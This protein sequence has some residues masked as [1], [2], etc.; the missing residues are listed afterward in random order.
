MDMYESLLSPAFVLNE[1]VARQLYE[2][3]PE[4]GLT[5]LIMDKKG[6]IWPSDSEE[7]AKF[8]INGV[9][10]KELR[11]KIDDGVEPV[12]T[13]IDDCSIIASQLATERSNCGYIIIILPQYSPESTLINITLIETLL[14]QFNLIANL[15]E[16]NNLLYEA[17]IQKYRD[18]IH[19]EI[20]LN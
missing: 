14:N 2:V 6:N 20:T 3:L 9:D 4:Q 7:F 16:K 5:I 12:I 10:L 17:Q 11:D 13:Q 15:L 19:S 18:R 8:N 1:Q